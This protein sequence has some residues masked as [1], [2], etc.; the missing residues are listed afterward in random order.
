MSYPFDN[1]LIGTVQREHLDRIFFWNAAD[2]TP[3]LGESR[4]Y[5]D[6]DRVPRA[7]AGSTPAQRA[8]APFPTPA[9]LGSSI[10]AVCCIR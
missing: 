10:A 5:Y 9:A 8:D 3:K 2:L 7:L 6:A 1:R 4:D